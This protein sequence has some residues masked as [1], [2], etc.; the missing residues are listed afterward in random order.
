M[1]SGQVDLGSEPVVL[2]VEDDVLIRFTVAEM[3]REEG[4]VVLEAVNASEALAMIATRQ[5]IDVV[6]SDV[7]MPGDIDGIALAAEIKAIRPHLPVALVSSHLPAGVHHKADG[8]LA[9]PF[10][11]SELLELVLSLVGSEWRSRRSSLGA[12]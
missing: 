3:L 12:S 4:Y 1:G 9:K 11:L 8:F 6:L 7:R 10:R 5:Q 2:L